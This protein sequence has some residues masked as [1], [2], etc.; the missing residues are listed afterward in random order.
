M[1]LLIVILIVLLG[2]AIS[3]TID[4]AIGFLIGRRF[5]KRSLKEKFER[6]HDRTLK[7]G[8]AIVVVG[9]IIPSPIEIMTLFLGGV[10]YPYM[11]LL[12]YTLLGRAAKFVLLAVAYYYFAASL[13]PYVSAYFPG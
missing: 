3:L 8:W 7:W 4:Y 11:K 1:N 6:W 12:K 2:N 9:N 10:R 5:V 13:L